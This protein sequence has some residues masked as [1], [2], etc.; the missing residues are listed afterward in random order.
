MSLRLFS[1][2]SGK[3]ELFRS[4]RK[5]YVSIYVCGVTP[6]DTTHLGHA[7]TYMS[8]DVLIRYLRFKGFR[9]T[10]AQ[11][12]TDID[13]D[14]L[15]RARQEGRE[16]R[17]LGG[18]WTEHYLNDMKGLNI[19]MPDYYIKAT[20]AI[21]M[22]TKMISGLLKGK[23]AYKSGG[24]VYFDVSSFPRYGELSHF[25]QKQMTML[26]KERG[27]DPEDP[28]KRNPLDFI[29]WQKWK[30][31]EPSWSPDFGKGRPGWHIE[32]SAMIKQY[33]GDQIDI[34][35]GGRD[36][37]FPHHESEIAQS[38]SYTGKH[39]FVKYFMHTGTVMYMGEKMAKSLGNLVMVSELLRSHS[40]SAVRWLLLSHHYRKPWEYMAEDIYNADIYAEKID[41][42]MRRSS[43]N[44]ERINKKL[45][46]DFEQVMDDDLNTPAALDIIKTL[47][48]NGKGKD[49]A[50]YLLGIL[51]FAS[52]NQHAI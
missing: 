40:P 2:A 24:N 12:V 47:L 30:R 20:D 44:A 36:L 51:G 26:L 48:T 37:I 14:I 27:G 8:F 6:Y 9:V 4:L 25:S 18:Y 28:N 19:A 50:R 43:V 13:D 22:I 38:E 5:G 17:E 42:L 45:V 1:S 35:G 3:K 7:F 29:L 15:R 49:T 34:H 11:N 52:V 41:K 23:H 16:W 31:G 21:P 46:S 10:Y 39:P 32:C 33:L